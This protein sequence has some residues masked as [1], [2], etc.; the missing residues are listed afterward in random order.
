MGVRSD[1]I[2]L[3]WNLGLGSSEDNVN[4]KASEATATVVTGMLSGYVGIKVMGIVTGK[5]YE[6]ECEADRKREDDVRPGWPD[7]IAV[8]K[9]GTALGKQVDDVQA[10]RFGKIFH[11]GTGMVWAQVYTFPRTLTGMH[12]V[13][14]WLL[15]SLSMWSILDEGLTPALGLSAP[16]SAYPFATH[17]R[18]FVGHMAYG[19]GV[20]AVVEALCWLRRTG[21]PTALPHR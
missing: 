13:A 11:Y 21:R 19:F 9:I 5:M 18:G 4:M 10:Q 17:I 16:N 3:A 7:Q 6:W 8:C 15:T 20:M 12:P 2:P 1:I 14:A